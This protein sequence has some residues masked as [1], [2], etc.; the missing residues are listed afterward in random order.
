MV[1]IGKNHGLIAFHHIRMFGAIIGAFQS[2]L[3]QSFHQIRPRHGCEPRQ[4]PSAP[5]ICLLH[6]HLSMG[7]IAHALNLIA[8]HS[9]MVSMRAFRQSSKVLPVAHTP[10]RPGTWAQY[11][12]GLSITSSAPCQGSRDILREHIMTPLYP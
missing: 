12:S 1:R 3:L 10:S 11:G 6:Y 8:I 5:W 4:L 9:S 7:C 2:Q